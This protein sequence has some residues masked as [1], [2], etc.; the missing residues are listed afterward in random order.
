MYEEYIELYR[1]H[2]ARYGPKTAI[3]LM[4]GSFYEL[5]DI[6]DRTTGIT[7]LNVRTITDILGIQLTVKRDDMKE[8]YG[9]PGDL[10]NREGLFAG[11]PEYVLHKHAAR[12]TAAGWTV[13]V[14]DQIK[15]DIGRVLRREVRRILSPSTHV[16]AMAPTDT[17]Y[18]TTVFIQSRVAGQPPTFGVATLDLTTGTTHTYSGNAVG[19][20]DMWT[21]DDL[22]QQLTIFP[23][24]EIL[25]YWLTAAAV[26]GG[27]APD[28]ATL[29]RTL[30]LPNTT[31]LFVR[32]VPSLGA[33]ANPATT[34]EYLRRCYSVKSMLPPREY[35]GIRSDIEQ[36]ALLFLLQFAEEHSPTA[37][38]GFQ[39]NHPWVPEQQLI[40][41]N[42]ALTQLQMTNTDSSLS[43]LG[44]FLTDCITPLGK[45][46]IRPRLLRP[47]TDSVAISTRLQ[48][49]ADIQALPVAIANALK[50]SLRFICDLPRLHRRCLLA[51]STTID[52]IQ[53]G[54]SYSAAKDILPSPSSS[55][56]SSVHKDGELPASLQPHSTFQTT[57]HAY[58]E[59]F[60]SHIDHEKGM[61]AMNSEDLTPFA[62]APYPSIAALEAAIAACLGEFETLRAD[63]C[64]AAAIPPESLRLE[65]REKEPFGLKGSTAGMRGLKAATLPVGTTLQ[66]LKSGGWVETPRLA[67]LNGRLLQLRSRLAY[68]AHAATLFVCQK[69][70]EAGQ[71]LWTELEE[72]IS[73]VDCSQCIATVSAAKGWVRPAL[74]SG[75]TAA[76]ESQVQLRGIRHPLVE[77]T[78]SR[79]AY[80]QHDVA[81]G[82]STTDGTEETAKTS[83]NGWLVYGMNASGK[84]TLM[85]AVGICI[86]LAQAGCFVPA[87]AMIF[88]PFR[89]V[90]TRILNHD[91]LFAGLSSFAVEMSELRDILRAANPYTL[92]LG[93]ELCAGTESVSAMSLV[94]A[95]IQWLSSKKAKYI[96]ATHLHDLPNLL[97]QATEGKA[98][99]SLLAMDGSPK[100]LGYLPTLGLQIWHLHVEYDPVTKKLVYD[101]R[102][103][104]GSG[105]SLYGLEVARAMD[106]PHEFLELAKANRHMLLGSVKEQDA[107]SSIWNTTIRKRSCELCG[108]TVVADLEVHHIEQRALAN[109]KGILPN[110]TPMNAPSNLVVLCEMCHDAHHTGTK[111]INIVVDTSEGPERSTCNSPTPSEHSASAGAGAGASANTGAGSKSKWTSEEMEIIESTLRQYKTASL[112]AVSYQLKTTGIDI[113]TQSLSAIRKRLV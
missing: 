9:G 10:A 32:P 57:F 54:Q 58:R 60:M 68:E 103:L 35:L 66:A 37:V 50:S 61:Q 106:L 88:T 8:A 108:H 101:R 75:S 33:F 30:S 97:S 102:L 34:A 110:G 47:L 24:K 23:P 104:P 63:L 62:A 113:S 85:K 26:S 76:N 25:V 72:W 95:G 38:H 16:E 43:V 51:Q 96:F 7:A 64:A 46:D 87:Q 55:S 90:Y 52:F 77:A 12:L 78:G 81:L 40:C 65:S 71:A 49:V 19:T 1:T 86:L 98:C 105:S 53:L 45:R 41:G 39:R 107:T 21:V 31:P 48:E 80:V 18:L 17:P 70:T 20:S 73:H 4:V 79:V 111:A 56:L 11:F 15:S 92:V 84:S 91:N 2:T 13:V 6:Q 82:T 112:K 100:V 83:A 14:V 44:L 74:V 94:S 109:E 36:T 28:E 3:F 67:K 93:D 27:S 99:H 89:A 59:L 22:V 69:L 29:R 42:H 5:Y